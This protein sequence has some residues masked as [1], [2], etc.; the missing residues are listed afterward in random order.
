MNLRVSEMYDVC[1]HNCGRNWS[2]EHGFAMSQKERVEME[3]KAIKE[4]WTCENDFLNYCPDCSK[5]K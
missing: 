2:D 4:G 5:S 1:C 3:E